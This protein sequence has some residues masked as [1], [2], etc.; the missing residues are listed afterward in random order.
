[1]PHA[2]DE[3]SDL[4]ALSGRSLLGFIKVHRYFLFWKVIEI[5]TND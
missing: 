2:D 5:S 3:C 1:M 4:Y